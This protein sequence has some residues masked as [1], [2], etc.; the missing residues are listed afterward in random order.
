MAKTEKLLYS[1][2]SESK[3]PKNLGFDYQGKLISRTASNALYRNPITAGFLYSLEKSVF[4]IVESV[5]YIK[6]A[7]SFTHTKDTNFIN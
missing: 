5:K 1:K 2:I 7:F 3:S 4:L 6:K